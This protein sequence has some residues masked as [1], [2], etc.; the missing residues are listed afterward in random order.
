MVLWSGNARVST[1]GPEGPR[2]FGVGGY[3][4][5]WVQRNSMILERYF[6]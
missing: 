5:K 4:G 3:V 1:F 6:P 2:K